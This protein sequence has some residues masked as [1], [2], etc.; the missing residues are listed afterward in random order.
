MFALSVTSNALSVISNVC[1]ALS[2]TNNA[3]SVCQER[4]RQPAIS[5]TALPTSRAL[6][7][8]EWPPL[9]PDPST[10]T[11]G[12]NSDTRC[13]HI[14]VSTYMLALTHVGFLC[15]HA[16]I[17]RTPIYAC[18][19]THTLV[20]T[21]TCV[22]ACTHTHIHARTHA[23]V[24]TRTHLWTHILLCTHTLACRHAHTHTHACM[25]THT[26]TH[27]HTHTCTLGS[28]QAG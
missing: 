10:S 4:G 8:R 17:A 12:R 5:R 20:H 6:A 26:H 1:V 22:W 7:G 21:D 15:H 23:C 11:A 16:C 3:L 19:H 24:H 2:V 28:R 14:C 25:H 9:S 18:T 13:S 27:M